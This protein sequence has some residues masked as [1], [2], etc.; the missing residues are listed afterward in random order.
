MLAGYRIVG[1]PKSGGMGTVYRAEQV[2]LARSVALKVLAPVLGSD[3]SFVQRF[4]EEARR[5]A[6]LDHPNIV[7][8]YD[9]GQA[10][11]L[12]FI[13]MRYVDGV[14]L[15]ELLAR[16]GMLPLPRAIHITA[17]LGEA[18]DY[19]HRRGIFHRDVKPS[20]VMV[21]PGDRVTLTDFGIAKLVDGTQLTRAGAIIGTPDYLSPE[22]GAGQEIDARSDLYS[23]G[24]V[25]YEMVTGR[26]PFRA[27]TPVAVVHAH[28]YTP[29]PSPAE[30]NRKLPPSVASVIVKALAKDP[31]RRYQT[32]R[33]LVAALRKASERR[34]PKTKAT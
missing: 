14:T 31:G 11:G 32:G 27:D 24:V 21:E 3:P 17:Q 26:T 25:L 9:S 34:T 18:L 22:Q 33:D 20:N 30:V 2:A 16:E 28:I 8:V 5:T 15:E 13:A 19:A 12:L 10:N 7:T 1:S 29:P 4:E 23:L 6:S